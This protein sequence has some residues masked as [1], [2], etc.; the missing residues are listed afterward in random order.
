MNENE[1]VNNTDTTPETESTTETVSTEVTTEAEATPETATPV[2]ESTEAPSEAASTEPVNEVVAE[3]V[4]AEVEATHTEGETTIEEIVSEEQKQ[5]PADVLKSVGS[6]IK[7]WRYTIIAAVLVV[8]AVIGML[9][10]MEERGRIHTGMFD[11]VKKFV[12]AHKA[13]AKV[14]K[15]A[16][17]QADLDTSVSQLSANAEAQGADIKDPKT[18]DQ[19]RS[20]ALDMLVNT[21]LLKQE[22]AKRKITISDDDVNKR[23]EQLKKDV[24]GEDVL[25]QRMTQFNIDEKTLRRDVTNELTIQALLDQ[26]FKEKAVTVSEDDIKKFYDQAGGGKPGIPKLS[27]VH[28]QIEAQLKQNKQQESVTAFIDELRKNAT[29]E[30][31]K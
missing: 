28:D 26:V 8:V 14:N 15:N 6:W 21:E 2:V 29:I 16:I 1:H 25:K 22:A 17:T 5:S 9:Y 4:P 19:I 3:A 18:L 12:A 24:G 20:Q 11:G 10:I 30:M 27:E 13:V 23:I 7:K 31:V